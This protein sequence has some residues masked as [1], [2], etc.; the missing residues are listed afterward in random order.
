LPAGIEREEAL[1]ELPGDL[2]PVMLKAPD[3]LKS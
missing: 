3:D 2:R 1:A